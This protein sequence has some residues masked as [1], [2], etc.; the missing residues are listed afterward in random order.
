MLILPCTEAREGFGSIIC[1]LQAHTN[2]H[3]HS[4]RTH[5]HTPDHFFEGG[6]DDGVGSREKQ[7][8]R[9]RIKPTLGFILSFLCSSSI[10][11][12]SLLGR[13][14]HQEGSQDLVLWDQRPDPYLL[15]L[16]TVIGLGQREQLTLLT[17]H[18]RGHQIPLF[19][20]QLLLNLGLVLG[21]SKEGTR[22]KNYFD[23]HDS[24][25][26]TRLA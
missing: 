7:R 20:D 15:H 14:G 9:L 16:N 17:S 23:I 4:A 26:N 12:N 10:P 21:G 5:T 25:L 11:P 22:R 3:S 6:Q 2:S 1:H 13:D 18:V 24:P 19:P 8:I